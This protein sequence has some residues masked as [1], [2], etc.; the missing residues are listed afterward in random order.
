MLLG[1]VWAMLPSTVKSKRLARK[2][3]DVKINSS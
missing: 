2:R 3:Q 1:W